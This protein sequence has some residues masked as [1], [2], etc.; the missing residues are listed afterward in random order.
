MTSNIFVSS[1]EAAR[2]RCVGTVSR[3]IFRLTGLHILLGI[4]LAG[5]PPAGANGDEFDFIEGSS[6][7]VLATLTT[8]GANPF[9]H[10]D[11]VSLSFTPDGDSAFGFGTG[12][13]PFVFDLTTPPNDVVLGGI[14]GGSVFDLL[15]HG[16][17][18]DVSEPRFTSD[19]RIVLF[20]DGGGRRDRLEL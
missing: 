19:S 9:A 2:K 5:M 10:T 14:E 3:R 15:Y 6:G 16:N 8:N 20:F 7:N 11:V 17:F 18:N 1:Q 13:I 12:I 4:L